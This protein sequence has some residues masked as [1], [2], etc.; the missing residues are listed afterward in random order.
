MKKVQLVYLIGGICLGLIL[1]AGFL[2]IST[3]DQ[4]AQTIPVREQYTEG[5]KTFSRSIDDYKQAAITFDGSPASLDQLQEAHLNCRGAFKEIEYLLEYFDHE[6]T[7]NFINGAPLP[8]LMP[9]VPEIAVLEPEGL[10]V[11]DELVFG[12]EPYAE[13]EAILEFVGMLQDNMKRISLYQ[14]RVAVYPRHVFEAA[15]QEI[16]RISTLGLTGFDT[17]GSI[18]A[19][20]EAYQAMSGVEA[21]ISSFYP[22]MSELDRT[23]TEALFAKAKKYLHQNTDFDTFDR[24]QY[25]KKHLNPLFAH[26]YKVHRTL[27]IETI[28]E[29][30]TY[31]QATN[32]EAENLFANDFL[33]PSYFIKTNQE[34]ITPDRIALGKLLFFD[35]ILSAT[36]E[37][38]CASCHQP[39]KG[40]TDGLPKSLALNYDGFIQ[41]N[42]PT[43][44]NSIYYNRWFHDLRL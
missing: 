43:V 7:K 24:L 11:L 31:P 37:R 20:P 30:S 13:R 22:L 14:Q 19:I 44:I 10:Q 1:L 26:L 2:P 40:F 25:L 32:Y 35:P 5:L 23:E 3:P 21:G 16:I 42:S 39:E 12:D 41:R 18:N 15:R 29:V 4:P 36:N 38:S 33:N 34:D 17:P 28:D 6:A 9:K 27:G 8:S